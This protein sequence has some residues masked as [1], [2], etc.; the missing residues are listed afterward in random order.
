MVAMPEGPEAARSELLALIAQEEERLEVVLAGHLEREEAEAAAAQ[1]IDETTY[2]ERLRGYEALNDRLL[3]RIVEALRKRH[4]GADGTAMPGV[5]ARRD[6]RSDR[7]TQG[8]P[9]GSDPP[10]SGWPGSEAAAAPPAEV[11]ASEAGAPG[12]GAALT[13]G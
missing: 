2:G 7:T 9:P 3:L 4:Q 12:G 1:A 5:R 10:R 6:E 8:V 13:A 11:P